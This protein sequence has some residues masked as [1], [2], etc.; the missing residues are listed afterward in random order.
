MAADPDVTM[1]IVGPND[2]LQVTGCAAEGASFCMTTG[3]VWLSAVEAKQ[4][5]EQKTRAT[6]VACFIRSPSIANVDAAMLAGMLLL[7][8]MLGNGEELAWPRAAGDRRVR[9]RPRRATVADIQSGQ[10][11][12]DYLAGAGL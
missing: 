2:I 10:Q 11:R 7:S 4:R 8:L 12:E 1:P 6:R 3:A 5:N 9:K